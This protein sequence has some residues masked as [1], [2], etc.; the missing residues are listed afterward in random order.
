MV[1]EQIVSIVRQAVADSAALWPETGSA[2]MAYEPF[3]EKVLEVLFNA[4]FVV[5]P[6]S[7]V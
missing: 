4:G 3:A 5:E 2:I 6:R 7:D 1:S